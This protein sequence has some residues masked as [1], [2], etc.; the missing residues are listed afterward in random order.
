MYAVYN[1]SEDYERA[2]LNARW[3]MYYRAVS[4]M[5]FGKKVALIVVSIVLAIVLVLLMKFVN[6]GSTTKEI[7][8]K[9]MQNELSYEFIVP[10]ELESD[11]VACRVYFPD[12]KS[13]RKKRQYNAL[14]N[15]FS[16]GYNDVIKYDIDLQRQDVKA[17]VCGTKSIVMSTA[18][19]RQIVDGRDVY[20]LQNER[21]NRIETKINFI[22]GGITY[23]ITTNVDI[24]N[25][26]KGNEYAKVLFNK[27]FYG[28]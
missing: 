6:L 1:I 23:I 16:Q 17:N 3:T 7:K 5:S 2:K 28:A 19:Q 18:Y 13:D 10:T 14:T 21:G 11:V 15:L 8:Y 27:I 26:D 9:T 24:E 20:Y 4:K 12:N 22:I 25:N